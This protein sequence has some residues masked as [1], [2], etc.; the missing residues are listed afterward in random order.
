MYIVACTMKNSMRFLKKIKNRTTTKWSES[1]SVVSNCLQPHGRY[2]PWNSPGQNTGV[3][4]LSLLHGIFQTQGL[5]PGLLHGRQIIYQ[6]SHKES[7]RILEW[8][9]CP[10][11]N[12]SSQ[13]NFFSWGLL[14]C[15]WILYQLSYQGSQELS[16][17]PAIPLLGIF[18]K[19][20]K[21][22]I[23]RVSVHPYVYCSIIYSC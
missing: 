16:Y 10:F 22:Q 12:G 21:I 19:K 2:S 13:P 15:R 4:C 5:N 3:G 23:P 11:S 14:H 1:H 20:R 9:V 7:P 8:V 18:L 6:L 17:D